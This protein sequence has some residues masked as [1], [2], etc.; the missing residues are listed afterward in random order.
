MSVFHRIHT[1]TEVFASKFFN[2]GTIGIVAD[3]SL[4][5]DCLLYHKMFS[6][7]LG[8]WFTCENYK[9]VSSV[10]VRSSLGFKTTAP[11]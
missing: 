5:W 8:L 2:H 11:Y 7:V 3:T 4:L 6:T 9:Q 10:V 1:K